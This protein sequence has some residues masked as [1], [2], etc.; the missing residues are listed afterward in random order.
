MKN[1]KFNKIFIVNLFLQFFFIRLRKQYL[2]DIEDY[3]LLSY[4]LMSDGSMSSRVRGKHV[5]YHNYCL[6][7][8]MMPFYGLGNSGGYHF[9]RKLIKKQIT[10]DKK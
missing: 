2:Y 3:E 7:F 4:D 9:T 10:K 6:W 8:F 1:L 5:K